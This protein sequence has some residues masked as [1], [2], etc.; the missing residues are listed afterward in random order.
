MLIKLNDESCRTSSMLTLINGVIA[1]LAFGKGHFY[2]AR[3]AKRF[4][5]KFYLNTDGRNLW[6]ARVKPDRCNFD[7]PTKV[8]DLPASTHT[9]FG[10]CKIAQMESVS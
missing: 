1:Q 5:P 4:W 6:S 8:L 10:F 9:G 2:S 7:E 3:Y